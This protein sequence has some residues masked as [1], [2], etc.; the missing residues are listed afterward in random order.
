MEMRCYDNHLKLWIP[1]IFF[2]NDFM[3]YLSFQTL[4]Y[5]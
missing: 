1:S 5:N 4:S 2:T 3:F